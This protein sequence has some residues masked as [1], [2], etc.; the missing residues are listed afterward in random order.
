MRRTL[1]WAA[2]VL[3]GRFAEQMQPK[4]YARLDSMGRYAPPWGTMNIALIV[5]LLALLVA[6]FRIRFLNSFVSLAEDEARDA[7]AKWRHS[8]HLLATA[9]VKIARL[10]GERADLQHRNES[11]QFEL[12][13]QLRRDRR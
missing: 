11:V 10:I 2:R 1:L 4:R 7:Y 9:N 6:L 12:A 8:E 13:R 5:T 3:V